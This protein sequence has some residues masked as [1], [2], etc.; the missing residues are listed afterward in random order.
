MRTTP[1]P[2]QRPPRVQVNLTLTDTEAQL[3]DAARLAWRQPGDVADRLETRASAA[4]RLVLE[5]LRGGEA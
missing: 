4:K 3:L 1:S 5:Q 2:P